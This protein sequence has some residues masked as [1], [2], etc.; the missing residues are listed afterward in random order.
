MIK[1]K[2]RNILGMLIFCGY[3]CIFQ[4]AKAELPI[5][6]NVPGI[7]YYTPSLI[8]NDAQKT[9]GTMFTYDTGGLWNSG[10]IADIAIDENGWPLGI[11]QVVDGVPQNV[12]FMLNPYY[13]GEYVILYDG[14]GTIEV[15]NAPNSLIE[16]VRHII[17]PGATSQ[18]NIWLHITASNPSNH[19]RNMRIIPVEYLGD[20]SNLPVFREDFMSGLRS[21]H[22]LRFMDPVNTNNSSHS[23][24]SERP[25]ITQYTQ[26]TSQGMA[27]EYVIEMC[28]QLREDCWIS[29]PH[30]ADDNYI[31]NLAQLFHDSLDSDLK[32]YV[33]FSNEIWNWS[34]QQ[35]GYILENAPNHPDSYVTRDLANLG[36][37]NDISINNSILSGSTLTNGNRVMLSATVEMP[38]PLQA[39][40]QY[41]VVN[42]S[43]SNFQLS[44]TLGG[45]AIVLTTNGENVK[46]HKSDNHPEKDAYMMARTFKI[47]NSVYSDK[48]ENLI[49]VA[50]GQHAWVDNS[51]RIL[52][53]LFEIDGVGAD[54]FSV[55][56]YFGFDSADHDI[57]NIMDPEEVTPEMI[58]QSAR[59]YFPTHSAQWTRDTAVY[60]N[61]YGVD[62]L[63]YEGGQHMQP[64]NQGEW[65][66]NQSVWDAQIH[67]G[68]YELYSDNF[69]LHQEPSVNCKLFMA[70]S[71]VGARE[72]RWG[73]WGHL[74]SLSQLNSPETL[75]VTAPKYQALLD[76]NISRGDV[77]APA[78]PSGLEVW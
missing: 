43:G 53:Y 58:L 23:L 31:Q 70:F 20:E 77:F 45:E 40:R 34:F 3:F 1:L 6:M 78:L 33:E 62:Y 26:G 2:Y 55:G 17:F 76:Y 61:Q 68:M 72:S 16:G 71:Y 18:I 28:N 7:T 64:Y 39:Y 74:E 9:S 63:V 27:W 42:A 41:Y 14:E 37:T 51:R 54:A 5:G 19:I 36:T 65:A 15:N 22:A 56:G 30:K 11:P 12:R 13:S 66:Y 21:F 25:K 29:V 67:P 10:K 59:D 24:W 52:R 47:F 49:N 69:M 35:S 32:L 44:D 50:T 73:S 75:M 8:F 57:W 48:R 38:S 46:V 4:E 60:A